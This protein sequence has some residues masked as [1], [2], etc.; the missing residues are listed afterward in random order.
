MFDI[1]LTYQRTF[2]L[3][4]FHKF[5]YRHIEGSQT[6]NCCRRFRKFRHNSCCRHTAQGSET[7]SKF[8]YLLHLLTK[9]QLRTFSPSYNEP[10]SLLITTIC[11]LKI[12]QNRGGNMA[13]HWAESTVHIS[14]KHSN[15][16]MPSRYY[17]PTHTHLTARSN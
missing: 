4:C 12:I 10:L 17:H 14:A 11:T 16:S 9:Q 5:Y 7:E 2:E 1:I 8:R 13:L 15:R 6:A 3:Y